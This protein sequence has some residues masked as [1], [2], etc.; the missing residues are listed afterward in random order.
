[1]TDFLELSFPKNSFSYADFEITWRVVYIY[2]L[3]FYFLNSI[4]IWVWAYYGGI[5]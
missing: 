1:M 2:A 3:L 4:P 5:A